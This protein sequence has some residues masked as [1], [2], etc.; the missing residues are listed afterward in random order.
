MTIYSMKLE[1]KMLSHVSHTSLEVFSKGQSLA[2]YFLHS[3]C[4]TPS[5]FFHKA[6]YKLLAGD[7]SIYSAFIIPSSQAKLLLSYII[8]SF[9]RSLENWCNFC[10]FDS[11][12]ITLLSVCHICS[13]YTRMC[14]TGINS[15][16]FKLHF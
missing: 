10:S 12:S 8:N 7:L 15:N 6:S 16:Y 3:S 5:M 11:H 4:M 13:S 9:Y 1:L 14:L 2:L